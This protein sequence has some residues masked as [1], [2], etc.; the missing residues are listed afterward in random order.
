MLNTTSVSAVRR[1]L[2]VFLCILCRDALCETLLSI[3][4]ALRTY[5]PY[6]ATI[7]YTPPQTQRF[8]GPIDKREKDEV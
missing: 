2:L 6:P 8:A 7:L 1:V 3:L 5:C 4:L